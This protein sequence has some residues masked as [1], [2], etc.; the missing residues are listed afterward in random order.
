MLNKDAQAI[1]LLTYKHSKSELIPLS[2][3][4]YSRIAYQ[5][6][7]KGLSGPQDLFQLTDS[8]ITTS[9]GVDE[10][11]A[12][13]IR[14]L[15]DLGGTASLYLERLLNQGIKVITRTDQ[16][17]PLAFKSLLRE[18]TPPYLSYVG[19]I[20]LLS[21]VT[22]SCIISASDLLRL[23]QKKPTLEYRNLACINDSSYHVKYL[24]EGTRSWETVVVFS[25]IGLNKLIQQPGVR[26]AIRE[27]DT[28][29]LSTN[30]EVS[31]T[32]NYHSLYLSKSCS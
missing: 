8:E 2:A 4:E 31:N 1:F 6:R 11:L 12:K 10:P 32:P 5:I 28:L 15:L 3:Q 9:L 18:N 23:K 21:E 26:E 14:G 25:S 22:E 29:I 13:R 16:E 20:G 30:T 17:Y 19:N 7:D 27:G 24:A